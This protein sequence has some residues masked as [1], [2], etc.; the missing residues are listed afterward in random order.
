MLTYHIAKYTYLTIYLIFKTGITTVNA[1]QTEITRKNWIRIQILIAMAKKYVAMEVLSSY[2]TNEI[3]K[4]SIN[5][6]I[7]I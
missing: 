6:C 4:Y 3:A 5:S 7:S 1:Q 2:R